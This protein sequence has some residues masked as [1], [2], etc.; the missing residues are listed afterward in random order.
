MKSKQTVIKSSIIVLMLVIFDQVTKYFA[1]IKLKANDAYVIINDVFELQYLENQSAA[2]S[3]DPVSIIHHFFPI[4]AFDENPALFLKTK[5]IFFIVLTAICIFLLI[6]L[7]L[8]IP[9]IKRYMV[10]NGVIIVLVAG[11][12]GNLID[13]IIHNYVI[14]FFYFSL[15]N[16]P[17]F[18]VADI[19]V[20]CSVFVLAYLILFFLNE[21]D[22]E[23]I[24]PSKK[25][26]ES[27][28]K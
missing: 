18:N 27:K 11:A 13:R 19:Y 1:T 2:F 23:K 6:K 3:L 7:Y 9:D 17:I 26:N 15:I 28:G 16:F 25:K 24:F 12:L 14:D 8:R 20:T 21:D 5:M 10:L 4:K 22:F